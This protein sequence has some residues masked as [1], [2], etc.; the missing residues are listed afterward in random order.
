MEISLSTLV[1]LTRA[2]HP[3]RAGRQNLPM[4][5][6]NQPTLER[7]MTRAPVPSNDGTVGP[8]NTPESGFCEKSRVF[9]GELGPLNPRSPQPYRKVNRALKYSIFGRPYLGKYAELRPRTTF[10]LQVGTTSL[11]LVPGWKFRGPTPGLENFSKLFSS[12]PKGPPRPASRGKTGK[13]EKTEK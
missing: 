8:A 13:H 9:S 10:F 6:E 4:G 3:Q 1:A 5:K 12:L 2:T 11:K 7:Y